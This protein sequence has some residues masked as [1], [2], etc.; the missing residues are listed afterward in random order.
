M[1]LPE[2]VLPFENEST[3][4]TETSSTAAKMIRTA[5]RKEHRKHRPR[6]PTT[7]NQRLLFNVWFR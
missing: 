6:N 7:Q 1:I 5:D 3:D 4:L 2:H